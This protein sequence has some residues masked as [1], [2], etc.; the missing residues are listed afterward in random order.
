MFRQLTTERVQEE[1]RQRN[2]RNASY[3]KVMDSLSEEELAEVRVWKLQVRVKDN[4][5]ELVKNN[6]TQK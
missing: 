3:Y 6:E 1:T 2:E 4:V 5:W